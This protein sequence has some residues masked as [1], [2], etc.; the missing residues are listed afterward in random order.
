MVTHPEEK[1]RKHREKVFGYWRSVHQVRLS[2]DHA[3]RFVDR[4]ELNRLIDIPQV[5]WMRHVR[6]NPK[7]TVFVARSVAEFRREQG[8]RRKRT[9]D[10]MRRAARR[11]QNDSGAISRKRDPTGNTIPGVSHRASGFSGSGRGRPNYDNDEERCSGC[12]ARF[13]SGSAAL[14]E[15]RGY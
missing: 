5:I 15:C 2:S 6:E 8:Q 11:K 9:I 13:S 7:I 1:L 10:Q 14:H 3:Q 4:R 12:G